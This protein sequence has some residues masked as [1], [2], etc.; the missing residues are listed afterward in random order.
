[1]FVRLLAL[2][3]IG[4]GA[5]P[6]D[7][8]PIFA[9]GF[10]HGTPVILYTDIVSGPNSGG[11]DDKGC[12]LSVFGRNFGNGIAGSDVRV[13]VG[14][15]EVD[16]YRYF[17]PSQGRAD[18]QQI[19]VQVGDL[20]N[21]APG[22]PLP[23]SVVVRGTASNA[24]HTFMVNP[25]RMIFVDP[26]AGD[27][28]TAQ[29]GDI[30]HP[31][32]HVQ[33]GND[34][35]AGAWGQVRAGD[36]LVLRGGT[37]SGVGS[38][39][40]FLRFQIRADGVPDRSSGTPP[41]GSPGTGPI[42]LTAYPGEDAFIDGDA[43]THPAGALS[44]LNGESYPLAGKWIVIAN[45][46][47][48][49][50]GYDGPISQQIHGDNWRIVN[51]ELSAYT[52]V[53]SGPSPS[54]MGGITGNGENSAWL[55]N[56]IHDIYGSLYEAHGI[57]VDGGGSYDIGYNVIQDIHSGKG[58]QTYSN[59][60]NGSTYIDH[61]RIHHNLIQRVLQYGINIADNSQN[62][63]AIWNNI[64]TDAGSSG[65]RFNTNTLHGCRVYNNTFY[66][67]AVG[68]SNS[69]ALSN[70]WNLPVDA[71]DLRNNIVWAHF[72]GAYAGGSVGLGGAVGVI[73]NNL[74]YDGS[75]SIGFDASPATGDPQLLAPGTDFHIGGASSPA[76]DAGSPGAASLVLDDYDADAPRPGG[77]AIDIGAYE[78]RP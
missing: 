71:I 25:G 44:G 55:G 50:G 20:G 49:G 10:E 8:D 77:A 7:A 36:F 14:G 70:D 19:S 62:D 57:Y 33:V 17:G 78:R 30:G 16:N 3:A 38:E 23:V 22:V 9:D 6:A 68:G 29:V 27:D 74:W 26:I 53:T 42:T 34:F 13:L 39:D 5:T 41:T 24:D 4:I 48:E 76:V 2:A 72:G 69:G 11:E 31:F 64:V 56:R 73:T 32:Q 45:L 47:V 46:R 43:A 65:L 61:V 40:Y 67:N 52:G 54:R 63:F 28:A 37:Y 58:I 59:G 60:G 1:M 75:G 35:A 66:N 18:V 21:P 15:V 51:N 12:Y